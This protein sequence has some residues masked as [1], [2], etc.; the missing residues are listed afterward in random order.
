MKRN[1]ALFGIIL[2]C[3]VVVSILVGVLFLPRLSPR[4]SVHDNSAL[5]DIRLSYVGYVLYLWKSD[6]FS[7]I[8]ALELIFTDEVH[9]GYSIKSADGSEMMLMSAE[10]TAKIVTVNIPVFNRCF[11]FTNLCSIID[12]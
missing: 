5:T 3:L 11:I 7:Q 8:K 6:Y 1:A 12:A 2:A 9:K 4:L 10:K